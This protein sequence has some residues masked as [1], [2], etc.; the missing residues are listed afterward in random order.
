MGSRAATTWHSEQWD[1]ES[2]TAAGH[3]GAAAGPRQPP[4]GLHPSRPPLPARLEGVGSK[5][6]SARGLPASAPNAMTHRGFSLG[7]QRHVPQ[8]RL[9][10]ADRH[11]AVGV[12]RLALVEDLLQLGLQ[13]GAAGGCA[14]GGGCGGG[15]RHGA[16]HDCVSQR[17]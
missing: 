17:L 4:Q 11:V 10:C 2:G 14:G 3:A 8:Q 13:T 12:P 5:G 15:G 16:P 1:G 7:H 9:H 6:T